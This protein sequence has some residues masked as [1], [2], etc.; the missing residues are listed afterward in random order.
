MRNMRHI[1]GLYNKEKRERVQVEWNRKEVEETIELYGYKGYGYDRKARL[2]KCTLPQF[3]CV[4]IMDIEDILRNMRSSRNRQCWKSDLFLESEEINNNIDIFL[5]CL[6]DKRK[7]IL[8]IQKLQQEIEALKTL[9]IEIYHELDHIEEKEQDMDHMLDV[10]INKLMNDELTEH[11]H[12]KLM[13]FILRKVRI[14]NDGHLYFNTK[15]HNIHAVICQEFEQ[16]TDD[17]LPLESAMNNHQRNLN[18]FINVKCKGNEE[19]AKKFMCYIA[20]T[21]KW[22]SSIY[23]SLKLSDRLNT[24]QSMVQ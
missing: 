16:L 1:W 7:D 17:N 13:T 9:N 10:I 5:M 14:S 23:S 18:L 12:K 19:M 21:K 8:K 4:S 3:K 6:R 20:K 24:K 11:Q 22:K 2:I 15:S